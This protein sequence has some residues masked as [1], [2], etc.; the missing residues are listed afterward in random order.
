MEHVPQLLLSE[1]QQA[2]QLLYDELMFGVEHLPRIHAWALR[3][4]LD[5]DAF[6]WSFAQHR[7]NAALLKGSATA[8]L[9]A[10][11]ASKPLRDSFLQTA[12]DGTKAWRAKAL[13]Q[14]ET[15]VEEF[16]KR[17]LVLIYMASGQPLR[18]S[19]LFSVTWRNTQRRRHV[20][21]KHGLAM[22]YT[23]Y[24]KGQ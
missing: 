8:L 15:V 19:E 24:H 18:E 2:R 13:A 21:L 9:T 14:Y 12:A 16:L 11:Q 23:T 1:L 22:L 4:N 3:D 20:Y 5:A 7:E 17:L 10:I 6:G